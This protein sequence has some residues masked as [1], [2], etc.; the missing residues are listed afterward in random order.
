MWVGLFYPLLKYTSAPTAHYF[1][2]RYS[3]DE[4]STATP[5]LKLILPAG[6][7]LAGRSTCSTDPAPPQKSRS[8]GRGDEPRG[9]AGV[10][11]PQLKPNPAAKGQHQPLV[12]PPARSRD[13]RP[14]AAATAP[15]TARLPKTGGC[16]WDGLL[17]SFV[18]R[19]VGFLFAV[20]SDEVCRTP[21]HLLLFLS[22][23]PHS[24]CHGRDRF[25]RQ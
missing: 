2:P 16:L 17:A 20:V 13:S 22:K 1:L 5:R 11:G 18:V 21:V 23:H 14:S 15:A 7:C 6:L 9:R 19:S 12:R 4:Q 10:V 24:P 3:A 8:P 25:A